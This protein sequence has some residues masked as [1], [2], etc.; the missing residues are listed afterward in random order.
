M[1]IAVG[2]SSAMVA[3]TALMGFVG[4]ATAGDFNPQWALPIVGFAA[5]GG[6]LGAK[7][8]VKMNPAKL[9]TLFALS[10]LAAAIFMVC[11]AWWSR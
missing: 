2:T 11:H 7:L 4:H 1:Q 5:A 9:K 6:L 10:T 8:S 3:G